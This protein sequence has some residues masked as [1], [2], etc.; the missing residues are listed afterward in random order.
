VIFHYPRLQAMQGAEESADI[1]A[2]PLERIALNA[3]FRALP[4]A[5]GNDGEQVVCFRSFLPGSAT[6]V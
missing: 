6:L 2:T 1:L 5:D 4:V 3:S